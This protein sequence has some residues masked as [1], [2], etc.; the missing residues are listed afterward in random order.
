MG[1]GI[2]VGLDQ[3]TV[4]GSAH[5]NAG[6]LCTSCTEVVERGDRETL[7]A[8]NLA[9]LSGRFGPQVSKDPALIAAAIER[10]F[11]GRL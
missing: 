6:R 4:C 2:R 5:E 11:A 7:T 8:R 1:R 3:C 10:R 9:Y